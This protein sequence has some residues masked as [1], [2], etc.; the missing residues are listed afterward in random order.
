M[1]PPLDETHDPK[2][3]S[4]IESANVAGTDFPVQNLPFGVFRRRDA[5]AQA[6]VGVAIGDRV[7]D[8][9]GLLG[10]SYL[11]DAEAAVRGEC[12]RVQFAESP[13]GARSRSAAALRR[14]LHANLREDAPASDSTGRFEPS[15]HTG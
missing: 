9:D 12:L 8:V 2:V 5:G 3:Q 10:H 1:T 7:L 4:W 11:A 15:G 14:R 6:K 13:D